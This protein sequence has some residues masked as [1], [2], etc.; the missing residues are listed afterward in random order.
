MNIDSGMV[1]QGGGTA[2]K[3]FVQLDLAA[4]A[5]NTYT[6]TLLV[7]GTASA[8]TCTVASGRSCFDAVHS[9]ALAAGDFL[10]IQV[11]NSPAATAPLRA[12]RAS[13]RY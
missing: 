7:N 2:T 5:P 6:V 3:L 10:Q 4:A 1:P 11:T 12:Y 13:F 8:L 9:V